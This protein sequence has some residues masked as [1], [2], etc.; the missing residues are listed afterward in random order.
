MLSQPEAGLGAIKSCA[1]V[2]SS[3]AKEPLPE[4]DTTMWQGALPLPNVPDCQTAA[5]PWGP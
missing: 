1:P 3:T 2:E 4:L 5:P